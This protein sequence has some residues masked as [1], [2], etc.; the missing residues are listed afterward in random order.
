MVFLTIPWIWGPQGKGLELQLI[1]SG[2]TDRA[3]AIF[4][5]DSG[6]SDN[7]RAAFER[8]SMFFWSQSVGPERRQEADMCLVAMPVSQIKEKTLS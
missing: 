4:F 5:N 1:D 6:D 7:A 8:E 2:P 3:N